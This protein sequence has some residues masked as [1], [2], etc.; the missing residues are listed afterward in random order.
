MKKGVKIVLTVFNFLSSFFMGFMGIALLFL[1]VFAEALAVALTLGYGNPNGEI[2]AAFTG[3]SFMLFALAFVNLIGVILFIV[4][5]KKPVKGLQIAVGAVFAIA[6]I[7]LG[8]AYIFLMVNLGF[9]QDNVGAYIIMGII[10]LLNVALYAL[11]A[12]FGGFLPAFKKQNEVAEVEVVDVESKEVN[13]DEPSVE[14]IENKN[15]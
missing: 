4:T 13:K 15:E 10:V 14:L 8:G 11:T 2:I 6:V 5:F 9:S 3:P 12:L 1:G 7:L